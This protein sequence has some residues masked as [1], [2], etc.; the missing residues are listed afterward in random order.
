VAFC[1]SFNSIKHFPSSSVHPALTLLSRT[2]PDPAD[3]T[4]PRNFTSEQATLFQSQ[5]AS[6]PAAPARRSLRSITDL[7]LD[8]IP[9]QFYTP[10][11]N[12]LSGEA[13]SFAIPRLILA[14]RPALQRTSPCA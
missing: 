12:S 11:M 3:K 2:G 8:P 13:A 1:V 7:A 9:Q 14:H 5:R 10:T 4:V 6:F